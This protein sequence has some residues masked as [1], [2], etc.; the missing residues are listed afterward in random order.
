MENDS[1]ADFYLTGFAG[2]QTVQGARRYPTMAE[3]MAGLNA[4]ETKAAM[5]PL[6]Q[7]EY[8]ADDG[9]AIHEPPPS[10]PARSKWPIGTL[11]HFAYRPLAYTVGDAVTEALATARIAEIFS[12]H[13]LTH[14]PPQW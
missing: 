6:A 8:S 10:G 3:A 12:A 11:V 1:I 4:G 14:N 7:L 9:V 13:G 2:G 5:G